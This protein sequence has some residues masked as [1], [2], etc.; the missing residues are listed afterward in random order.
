MPSCFV[1]LVIAAELPRK[2]RF[3]GATFLFA[4]R[5]AGF[6]ANVIDFAPELNKT[7]RL[8]SWGT[9]KRPDLQ[10]I[11]SSKARSV[12]TAHSLTGVCEPTV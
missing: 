9:L 6:F 8:P 4:S 1:A 12:L 2:I 5:T 10:G 7:I 11:L 3:G